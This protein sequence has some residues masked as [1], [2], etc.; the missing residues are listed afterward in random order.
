[1]TAM[2]G[3][4]KDRVILHGADDDG[5]KIEIEVPR[6]ASEAVGRGEAP[7]YRS[8]DTDWQILVDEDGT[9]T[10]RLPFADS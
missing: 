5:T 10:R 8:G 2:S 9:T 7:V 1:M 3:E 4:P 6:W